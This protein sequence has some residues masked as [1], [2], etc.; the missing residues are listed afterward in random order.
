MVTQKK[1]VKP[2]LYHELIQLIEMVRFNGDWSPVP[3]TPYQISQL[4]DIS[5]DLADYGNRLYCEK[6]LEAWFMENMYSGSSEYGQIQSVIG[7]YDYY[8]NCTYTYYTNFLDVLA[9]DLDNNYN[10]SNCERCNNI[11]RDFAKN[12]KIIEIK[13]DYISDPS[14]VVDQVEAYIKWAQTV[15]NPRALLLVT[16]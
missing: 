3:A 5:L 12:V 1:I 7:D 14:R 15:L 16:S 13:R 8:S 6:L 9:Y 10:L 11:N 4:S 2:L